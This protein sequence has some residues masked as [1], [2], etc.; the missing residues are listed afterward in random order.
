MDGPTKPQIPSREP[1]VLVFDQDSAVYQ[2]LRAVAEPWGVAVEFYKSAEP[3]FQTCDPDQPGCVFADPDGPGVGG[4]GLLARLAQHRIYL[5]VVFVSLCGEVPVVVE[6]MKAGAFD[7]LQKPCEAGDLGRVLAGA[8]QWDAENHQR[9][10]DFHRVQRRLG[11]L[12]PGER[13]VLQLLLG[14]MGN[15]AMAEQL[16]LSVR[17]IEVRRAKIM[18]KMKARSVAEL[19]CH[20]V[21]VWQGAFAPLKSIQV[22][23]KP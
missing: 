9:L 16:K 21:A 23:V 7:Y 8:L 22:A 12:T 17:A 13:E 14:G 19:V 20:A 3:Y 2:G 4:F 10:A 18:E 5:P 6:A 11:R 1:T 15:R